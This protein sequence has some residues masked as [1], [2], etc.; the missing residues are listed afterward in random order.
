MVGPVIM[1]RAG[2]HQPVVV[3]PLHPLG[4]SMTGIMACA[5]GHE[6]KDQQKA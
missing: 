6:Q 1:N 2:N 3:L 5:G 4:L